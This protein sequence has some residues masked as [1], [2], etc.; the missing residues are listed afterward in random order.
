MGDKQR[1]FV[2]AVLPHPKTQTETKGRL[3]SISY[4]DARMAVEWLNASQGTAAYQNVIALRTELEEFRKML[5]S[6]N[7]TKSGGER[8]Y[9]EIMLLER[10]NALRKRVAQ[11][12]HVPDFAYSVHSGIWRFGMV[13]K[14]LRG[15]V[16]TIEDQPITVRVSE[17]T[18]IDALC[19][20]ATN[21][22]LYKV[23]LCEECGERWRVSE[24]E[25]D[26]FCTDKCREINKSH[27]QEYKDRKAK[28]RSASR[29]RKRQA[30]LDGAN[31]K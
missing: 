22:E 2:E 16:I 23:R 18:V 10:H 19:R 1:L 30:I 17:A 11:Y 24:R 27:S 9:A 21:R 20:L 25:M 3:R 31:L 5:D 6:L 7:R 12:L 8:S 29:E 28:N 14:R 26:R 4:S 15:P 13:P